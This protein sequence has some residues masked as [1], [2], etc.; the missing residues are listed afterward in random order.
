M[1]DPTTTM[2]KLRHIV[3]K[4]R[5]SNIL[6]EFFQEN[7]QRKR[8]VWLVP[9]LNVRVLWNSTHKMIK[10]ALYL[11][12]NLKCLLAINNSPKVSKARIPLTLP[13]GDLNILECVQK[14]LALLGHVTE[15]ASG[16][17]YPT[18]TSQLPYYQFLQNT[19]QELIQ[20]DRRGLIDENLAHDFSLSRICA[21]ADDAYQ[22]LNQYWIK[23]V[24]N[25][26]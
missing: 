9:V 2:H 12:P 21:A 19:L 6:W 11:R 4:I 20:N 18:L 10:R 7:V 17:T 16:S 14:V 1:V 13:Q 25:T 26:G 3:A 15:F 8:I 24:S 5:F 23:T 22:K